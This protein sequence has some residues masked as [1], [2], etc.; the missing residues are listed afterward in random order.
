MEGVFPGTMAV[1]G[2]AGLDQ[3]RFGKSFLALSLMM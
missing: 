3:A 2:R 1:P